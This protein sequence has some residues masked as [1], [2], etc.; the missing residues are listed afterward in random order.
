MKIQG[1]RIKSWRDYQKRLKRKD[2]LKS[3][4]CRVPVLGVVA[5]GCLL[6]FLS[7]FFAG[8]WIFAH[9]DEESLP[10][11]K[12]NNQEERPKTLNTAELPGLLTG[13]DLVA[14]PDSGSYIFSSQGAGL[15]AST[16]IDSSLQNR[17][18]RLLDRSMTIQAAAVALRP[19][20][21]QVLAMVNSVNGDEFHVKDL[22][23]KADIP[24]ASLFKIVA[25]AAAI[26]ARD[27]TPD[28]VLT[29][30][31]GKY[32]LYKS[33]LKQDT[34]RY[35]NKISFKRAFSGSVNPVF[36][37]IGIYE[38]GKDLIS[39]YAERFLFNREIPFDLPLAISSIEVPED[40]FGLAEIA[41]GFNKRTLLSPLHAAMITSAIANDGIMMRPWIVTDVRDESGKILYRAG[42]S[43]LADP[44]KR[45]TARQLQILMRATVTNGT[46]SSTFRPLRR[47]KTFRNV[48]LG[49]KTGT[50]NDPTDTYKYDWLAAYALPQED[51]GHSGICIAVLVV[52]GEK[53]GI[54][55]KDI[56]REILNYHFAS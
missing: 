46:C 13:L 53:L 50:I 32:T 42:P 20:T 12:K 14:S 17:I 16:S 56:A 48:A 52:H 30:R 3:C 34:G 35:L 6:V 54:R 18:K 28:K 43:K 11:A 21:G 15:I 39:Q 49:A 29:Y 33:Q 47:R 51:N 40:D 31:G 36:G 9:L 1:R 22:C 26:E 44:I 24:A 45:E 55:A 38:L 5:G 25:A 2:R 7:I 8:S 10:V 23:L 37:K 41:S 19:D 27:F 4:V